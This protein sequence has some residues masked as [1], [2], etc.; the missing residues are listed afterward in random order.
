MNDHKCNQISMFH[1]WTAAIIVL[2]ISIIPSNAEAEIIWPPDAVVVNAKGFLTE[3]PITGPHT[4]DGDID[5]TTNYST[6]YPTGNTTVFWYVPDYNG[7]RLIMTTTVTVLDVVP[8]MFVNATDHVIEVS[9]NGKKI[10]VVF[11]I[12]K[13]IDVADPDVKVTS[14]HDVNSMF[15]VGNTTVLFTAIDDF[16]NTV[17]HEMIVTVI[18]KKIQNLT[19]ERLHNSIRATWDMFDDRDAYVVSLIEYNTGKRT[20]SAKIRDTA[21]TFSDLKSDTKYTVIVQIQGERYIKAKMSTHTLPTPIVIRDDFSSI[22]GWALPE[23][24]NSLFYIDNNTGNPEPS[25]KYVYKRPGE[26]G[27]SKTFHFDRPLENGY[28]GIH[29]KSESGGGTLGT[30]IVTREHHHTIWRVIWNVA[31]SDWQ[32]TMHDMS[33]ILRGAENATVNI[34]P[35]RQITH[36]DNL[37]LAEILPITFR[38]GSAIEYV[39]TPEQEEFERVLVQVLEDGLDP[40]IYINGTKS[41]TQYNDELI[42]MLLHFNG[43]S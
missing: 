1:I 33:K 23:R 42:D 37:Y 28:L 25:A 41:I 11:K 36:L 24:S 7:I 16:G 14:S 22:G 20:Q 9:K 2:A 32:V 18:H 10:P 5:Y 4:I 3:V 35:N 19:L 27:I 38:G 31:G 6:H 29:I 15:P 12:P 8:P 34:Y 13:A 30:I 43:P 39:L 17:E 40:Q 21:H 26:G